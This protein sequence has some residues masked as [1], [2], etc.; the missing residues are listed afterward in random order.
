MKRLFLAKQMAFE[1]LNFQF[2]MY[3]LITNNSINFFLDLFIRI[4]RCIS[5]LAYPNLHAIKRLYWQLLFC[6]TINSQKRI[7]DPKQQNLL[8]IPQLIKQASTVHQHISHILA[9]TFS[10]KP[11]GIS[12]RHMEYRYTQRTIR[13]CMT[14]IGGRHMII[15]GSKQSRK[16]VIRSLY[17]IKIVSI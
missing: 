14:S 4:Y 8:R 2:Q 5:S 6:G 12:Y 15:E 7:Q 9:M 13:S 11:R 17:L 16:S 10:S 3:Q 1:A